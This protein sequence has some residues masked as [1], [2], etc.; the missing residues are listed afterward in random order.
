M[1][2]II[3]G[4]HEVD[5][6]KINTQMREL[7]A[8]TDQF[9]GDDRLRTMFITTELHPHRGSLPE[10]KSVAERLDKIIEF[11]ADKRILLPFVEQLRDRYQQ[12]DGLRSDLEKFGKELRDLTEEQL[13][14]LQRLLGSESTEEQNSVERRKCDHCQSVFNAPTGAGESVRCPKC[15]SGSSKKCTD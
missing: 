12:G 14:E 15:S 9:K 8:R 11:I 7:F 6:A 13:S 1:T 2:E 3:K 4:S 10:S 5:P